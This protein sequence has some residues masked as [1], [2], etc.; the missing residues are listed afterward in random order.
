MP[1]FGFRIDY[2]SLSIIRFMTNQSVKT[3]DGVKLSDLKL[4]NRLLIEN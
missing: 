1:V 2:V 3:L 4:D